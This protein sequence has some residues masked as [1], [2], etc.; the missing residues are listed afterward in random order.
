MQGDI[1]SGN[2]SAISLTN[3]DETL[4]FKEAEA[5]KEFK[6]NFKKNYF[7]SVSLS[8]FYCISFIIPHAA[9]TDRSEHCRPQC[10][11]EV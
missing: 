3:T 8:S 10:S 1:K 2:R 7:H 4:I 11:A 5:G 9:E 6:L